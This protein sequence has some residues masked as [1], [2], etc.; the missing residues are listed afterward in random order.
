MGLAPEG[1]CPTLEA[2][3][4][5]YE[6][7]AQTYPRD[8]LPRT[9]LFVIYAGLGDYEK[10]LATAQVA[11]QL[12]PGSGLVHGVLMR[13]YVLLNRLE[14]AKATADEAQARHL[15]A[16][17]IQ[18]YLVSFLQHDAAGMEREAAALLGKP[19]YED[20]VL[21]FQ[22]DTAAYEGA[23]ARARELTRRAV[24][25]AERADKSESAAAYQAEGAVRE[26]LAGNLAL[27][28][29]QAR[30]ALALSNGREAE[31]TSAIAMGLAG[32]VRQATR[33]AGDLADFE[34]IR[35][36]GLTICR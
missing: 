29:Q 28:K 1:I 3:R 14:E 22:S 27:A 15:G 12:N 17:A 35:R 34:R 8:P 32:E 33:L 31:A 10:A 36:C 7:W 20:I 5:T 2:A 26:A 25:S 16:P 24:S 18:L 4:K 9:N 19:G 13:A 11:L 23:L 30:A 21:Y 6:L